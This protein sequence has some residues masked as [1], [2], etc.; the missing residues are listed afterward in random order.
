MA[1]YVFCLGDTPLPAVLASLQLW[2]L[3]LRFIFV[4]AFLRFISIPFFST[5][6][7][8]DFGF[9]HRL[10]HPFFSYVGL[11]HLTVSPVPVSVAT[12][13]AYDMHFILTFAQP[14]VD[15]FV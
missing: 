8:F 2:V 13:L 4:L 6:P 11:V 9:G 3:P 15:F 7:V 5:F 10:F 14:T 1:D 12:Y